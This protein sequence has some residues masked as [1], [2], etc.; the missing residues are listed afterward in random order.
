MVH[1]L[2][3]VQGLFRN[4]SDHNE[5]KILVMFHIRKVPLVL[6]INVNLSKYGNRL[7]EEFVRLVSH[8]IYSENDKK[9]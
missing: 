3:F 6:V 7:D 9:K 4:V 8:Y 2:V 1:Q 5:K